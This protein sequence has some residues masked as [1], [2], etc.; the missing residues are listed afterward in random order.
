MKAEKIIRDPVQFLKDPNRYKSENVLER[1]KSEDLTTEKAKAQ[2][3]SRAGFN[4][5]LL[6]NK[7]GEEQCFEEARAKAS[8]YK[9][10]IGS[11]MNF[12]ELQNAIHPNQSSTMS[13]DN[14]RG[15]CMDM[16]MSESVSGSA[17]SSTGR[18]TIFGNKHFESET[19]GNKFFQH[20][21]GS[22]DAGL[23]QTAI[24][25]ASSTINDIDIACIGAPGKQEEETINTKFAMRELSMMFSSPAF[26]IENARRRIDHSNASRIDE[27]DAYVGKPD[28]SFGNVGDGILLDNSICNTAS[29]KNHDGRNLLAECTSY[30]NLKND[31]TGS[32]NSNAGF[33]IFQDDA[34]HGDDK[35]QDDARLG[36]GFKIFDE[37]NEDSSERIT[38]RSSR[39]IMQSSIPFQVFDERNEENNEETTKSELEN[40]DTA[41]IADAIAL[42]DGNLEINEMDSSSSDEESQSIASEGDETATLSLFNAIFQSESDKQEDKITLKAKEADVSTTNG[43]ENRSNPVRY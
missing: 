29:E 42:L 15:A 26:E 7:N 6:K 17:Q 27:S 21:G 18:K 38:E 9:K 33:A 40:G 41:N 23:N 8:A 37:G 12:N 20:S 5:R 28:T 43:G 30:E 32:K 10:L 11:S 39:N 19:S 1:Q 36:S 31:N 34:S 3:K 2:H 24:S 13:L 14:D 25:N 16:S 22:F 4:K 35:Y